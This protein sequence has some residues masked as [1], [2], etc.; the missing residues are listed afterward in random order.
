MANP[1][2]SDFL[3]KRALLLQPLRDVKASAHLDALRGIAAIAVLGFHFRGTF[4]VDLDPARAGWLLRLFYFMTDLGHQAVMIFFVLSGYLIGASVLR[5]F[6]EQRWSW[7]PYLINRLSRLWTVLIPALVLGALWDRGGMFWFGTGGI[8][9]GKVVN[10]SIS[11]PILPASNAITMLGNALFL[12]RVLVPTFG[13]NG[14]LWSLTYEFW[15]YILFPL[16]LL[17]VWPG[18]RKDSRIAGLAGFSIVVVGLGSTISRAFAI[19]LMGA[20][21]NFLPTIEKLNRK[22][23]RLGTLALFFPALVPS[24]HHAPFLRYSL[25]NDLWVGGFTTL[26]IYIL[27]QDRRTSVGGRYP[28]LDARVAG[29]SYT[30]YLVHLPLLVFLKALILPHSR[31]QMDVWSI[32][33]GGIIIA[34]ILG[35]ALAVASQTEA[36]TSEVRGMVMKV[37]GRRLAPG[38]SIA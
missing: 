28:D 20:G 31:W 7:Q 29:F 38:G 3:G 37:L 2:A 23:I 10:A 25:L 34:A 4:F 30:L 36:R 27:L 1:P 17:M 12:Q 6:H 5:N 32:L 22:T 19:W 21:L 35:Y 9:G 33:T 24:A 13:S 14:P 15:Y 11:A 18:N 26:L 8:Y 16:L